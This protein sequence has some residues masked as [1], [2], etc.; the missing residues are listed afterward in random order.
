MAALQRSSPHRG[1]S[2]IGSADITVKMP[3]TP[4]GPSESRDPACRRSTGG[5]ITE[6]AGPGPASNLHPSLSEAEGHCGSAAPVG[7]RSAQCRSG[8]LPASFH[9]GAR[10]SP[11]S[12][13]GGTT[14]SR[15]D[16]NSSGRG[17]GAAIPPQPLP[18]RRRIDEWLSVSRAT[19]TA[20]GEG[21][22]AIPPPP[23]PL[24]GQM[25]EWLPPKDFL[26]P[27][28]RALSNM[29]WTDWTSSQGTRPIGLAARAS[30][31]L[32]RPGGARNK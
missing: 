4:S 1:P 2:H 7:C 21:G 11:R 9:A 8:R 14:S 3:L 29:G 6:G 24:R 18:L 10:R 17:G 26:P 19:S 13:P 32:A 20:P 30:P 27:E 22:A 15:S 16:F 5:P 28:A 31:D 25:E 12:S 23:P